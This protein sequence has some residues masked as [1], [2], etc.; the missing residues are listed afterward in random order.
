MKP[1][2]PKPAT[3]PLT[4]ITEF[5]LNTDKRVKER[6]AFAMELKKKEEQIAQLKKE[7]RIF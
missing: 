5:S 4:E 1:F 2:E 6:E 7:V 3:K